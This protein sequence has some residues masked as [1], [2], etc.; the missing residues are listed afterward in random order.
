MEIALENSTVKEHLRG[1][2]C[3]YWNDVFP[4]LTR[5]YLRKFGE[6]SFAGV[7]R[8]KVCPH[9]ETELFPV[10][11]LRDFVPGSKYIN[12]RIINGEVKR[13]EPKS[14]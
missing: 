3:T 14:Y 9:L 6:Q 2:G 10:E 8:P 1:K 11:R 7:D 4:T 12:V 13:I 5:N